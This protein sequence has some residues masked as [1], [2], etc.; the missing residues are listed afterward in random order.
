MNGTRKGH[1]IW[2]SNLNS[3]KFD[4]YKGSYEDNKK[5]GYGVYQWANETIY[6]GNFKNDLRHDEGMMVFPNGKV[7]KFMWKEGEKVT[8]LYCEEEQAYRRTR[9]ASSKIINEEKAD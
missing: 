9:N 2:I 1:G 3:Q 8:K 4:I 5:N 6:D 7:A